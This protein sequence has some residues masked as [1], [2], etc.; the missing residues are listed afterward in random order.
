MRLVPWTSDDL[1]RRMWLKRNGVWI[2]V[3]Q[4]G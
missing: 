1:G 4:L 3:A 2:N